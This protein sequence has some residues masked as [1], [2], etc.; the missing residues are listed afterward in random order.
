MTTSDSWV[1]EGGG[2]HFGSL[3]SILE[4]FLLKRRWNV[5]QLSEVAGIDGTNSSTQAIPG[6]FGRMPAC[7]HDMGVVSI[8]QCSMSSQTGSCIIR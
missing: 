7:Q 8:L 3:P 4:N 2:G 6:Y 5:G 1:G